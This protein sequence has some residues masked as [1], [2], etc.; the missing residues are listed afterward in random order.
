[1]GC[2]VNPK[3]RV[4]R[5]ERFRT[6]SSRVESLERIPPQSSLFGSSHPGR[7][8]H[9]RH[10]LI[11]CVTTIAS[12]NSFIPLDRTIH[13]DRKATMSSLFEDLSLMSLFSLEP[14]TQSAYHRKSLR[15]RRSSIVFSER[16]KVI[17]IP[18]ARYLTRKDRKALWYADPAESYGKLSIIQRLTQCTPDDARD[19][20][21]GNRGMAEAEE[22]RKLP[23]SAVLDEQSSQREYGVRDDDFIA[24][25]YKQCSAHSIMKA[26]MRA[27]QHEQEAKECYST[28]SRIKAKPKQLFRRKSLVG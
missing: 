25:I 24:K 11:N 4:E 22:R 2:A 18:S 9:F 10:I 8:V 12:R 26:Q 16:V 14:E 21:D 27:L 6:V 15:K 19:E 3:I 20:Y 23:V 13:Q 28:N 1:M 5:L 17:E 7:V